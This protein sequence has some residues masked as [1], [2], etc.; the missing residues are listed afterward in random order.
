MFLLKTIIGI[1]NNIIKKFY[2]S[3]IR[4]VE[5]GLFVLENVT[6]GTTAQLLC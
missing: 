6:L 4:L 2:N 3:S 5:N 1:W